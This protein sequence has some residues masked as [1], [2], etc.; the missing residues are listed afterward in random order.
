MVYCYWRRDCESGQAVGKGT[1]ERSSRNLMALEAL[2]SRSN[3]AHHSNVVRF[4][5]YHEYLVQQG[6]DPTFVERV[7][8]EVRANKKGVIKDR[9][10]KILES[11][12]P[13][14]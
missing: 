4:R 11:Y 1:Q 5:H 9:W 2:D 13:G 8:W 10:L 14:R 12:L 7:Y 6:F 3:R